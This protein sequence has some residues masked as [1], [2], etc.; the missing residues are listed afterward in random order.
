MNTESNGQG[1]AANDQDTVE[2]ENEAN[3]TGESEQIAEDSEENKVFEPLTV[4]SWIG[5]I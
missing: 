1:S 2:I 4:K 5:I 3:T